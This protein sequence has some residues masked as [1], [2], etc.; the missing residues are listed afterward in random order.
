MV[1]TLQT[2]GFDSF[3]YLHVSRRLLLP[4]ADV[5]AYV[6]HLTAGKHLLDGPEALFPVE[7]I[8]DD[9]ADVIFDVW[10]QEMNR[11][12]HPRWARPR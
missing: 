5:L 12:G 8:G 3:P 11:Q 2:Y 7:K 9:D 6:D 10:Q 4:Y 1:T